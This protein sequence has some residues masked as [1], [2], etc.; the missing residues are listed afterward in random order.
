MGQKITRLTRDL[1]RVV[2]IDGR[3][4]VVTLGT[5]GITFRPLGKRQ[6]ESV[7]FRWQDLTR[8]AGLLDQ[9]ELSERPLLAAM[10]ASRL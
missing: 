3:K 8:D 2:T 1:R 7:P 5:N 9:A 6:R 4:V 10:L